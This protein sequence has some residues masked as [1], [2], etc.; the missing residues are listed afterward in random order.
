MVSDDQFDGLAK[1][2]DECFFVVPF[3]NQPSKDIPNLVQSEIHPI[4][5][6]TPV[7]DS[8]MVPGIATLV[9][10][11][12]DEYYEVFLLSITC[13]ETVTYSKVFLTS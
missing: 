11:Q 10:V 13:Q 7:S 3:C 6:I 12:Q 5:T 8:M 1:S 9:D 2:T 4:F